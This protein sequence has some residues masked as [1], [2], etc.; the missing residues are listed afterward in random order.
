MQV[1]IAKKDFDCDGNVEVT[2]IQD[3][4]QSRAYIPRATAESIKTRCE[5]GPG[6][7]A[8]GLLI[9]VFREESDRDYA[10]DMLEDIYP[11]VEFEE[12]TC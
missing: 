8:D 1:D 6:L 7:Q 10:R 4:R 2:F 5:M 11:D 3:G 9:A 12:V